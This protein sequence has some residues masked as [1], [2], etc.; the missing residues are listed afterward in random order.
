MPPPAQ[1]TVLKMKLLLVVTCGGLGICEK[2]EST[3]KACPEC[4]KN[5]AA[6]PYVPGNGHP[7][8]GHVY[9]LIMLVGKMFLVIVD[10]HSK[11]MGAFVSC[12][13]VLLHILALSV[14]YLSVSH[15][16]FFPGSSLCRKY[17]STS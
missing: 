6:L 16:F 10:A 4:Q 7:S 9:I 13:V 14:L 12:A 15:L 8:C 2:L 17:Y 5:R 3:V 1:E 11:W